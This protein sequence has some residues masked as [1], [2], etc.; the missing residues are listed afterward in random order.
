MKRISFV[1][2]S[3]SLLASP[4]FAEDAEPMDSEER[5]TAQEE[6]LRLVQETYDSRINEVMESLNETDPAAFFNARAAGKFVS[7]KDFGVEMPAL[8]MFTVKEVPYGFTL[9]SKRNSRETVT[10]LVYTR[11][12]D[13][14]YKVTVGKGVS[15]DF[16][17]MVSAVFE[18]DGETTSREGTPCN[19]KAV[20]CL[21][22]YEK[23][24]SGKNK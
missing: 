9:K 10:V 5:L 15:Y 7:W 13:L 18:S 2:L 3:F 19:S 21:N 23:G 12:D 14:Y 6:D 11:D 1:I 20:S 24:T 8:R 16:S 17:R 22:G 4:I